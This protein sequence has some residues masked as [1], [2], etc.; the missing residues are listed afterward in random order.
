MLQAD[1][2]SPGLR[3]RRSGRGFRYFATDGAPLADARALARIRAL[4]I[5][6]AWEDVWICP[7]PRGHIQAV[8]TDASGRRQYL[9]HDLWRQRRDREKFDRVMEFGRAL[10]HLR[11]V[12]E[13]GLHGP[14]LSRDR[15]LAAAVRLIDLGFFRPGGEEYAA[16]NGSY[17]LATIRREHVTCGK[18]E[19]TFDYTGKSGKHREQSVADEAVCAVVRSLKRR[20]SGGDREDLLVYRSGTQW[21]N[22]TAAEI[23]D[24]LRDAAGGD[25]TAKDFRTWHATVL[26]AVGL[27]VSQSAAAE[28]A[29]ARKRAVARVVREV[30]G[31]LGNTP[32]VA[33]AS[34]IDQV[35]AHPLAD[36]P[37]CERRF[38]GE[39]S[40]DRTGTRLGEHARRRAELARGAIAALEGVVPEE[41]PQQRMRLSRPPS[42]HRQALDRRDLRAVV[43]DGKREAG[44]GPAAVDQHRAG[45]ALA[46]VAAFLGAGQPEPLAEQIEQRRPVV[47]PDGT[48][49]PVARQRD[50][51][52]VAAFRGSHAGAFLVNLTPL[53]LVMAGVSVTGKPL[54]GFLLLAGACR[55]A[56]TGVYQATGNTAIEHAAGWLGVPLAVFA[57]YGGLALLLE[58]SSQRMVLP[59]GRR[60]RARTSLEGTFGHQV[61]QAEQEAGVR[62]Q[63]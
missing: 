4:T 3:R 12:V 39:V 53:M 20:R 61:R 55:F 22:V 36:L 8:G 9:Y 38:R 63:L 28:S 42:C 50:L 58:E 32:A 6:P 25:F 62:R 34:Y 15:V 52:S 19:L 16:E 44:V 27:A 59:L 60:G 5:P 48:G 24:Y 7:H 33:R 17:G 37:R 40:T 29:A 57:L 41:R 30:A 11:A 26:A 49:L 35:P 47:R 31:Y 14:G 1:L 56:L 18:G 23:N 13:R 43:R 46:V 45:A 54:F 2:T 10:P 21:H 51:G